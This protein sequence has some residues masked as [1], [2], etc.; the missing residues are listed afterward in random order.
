[1]HLDQW[2]K[3]VYDDEALTK[4]GMGLEVLFNNMSLSDLLDV[5]C[6]RTSIEKAAAK[7]TLERREGLPS[8]AFAVPAGKAK[9]IGVA[10]EIKGEAKGK[11]PIPDLKHAKNALARVSQHGT[12]AEREAVRKKVYAKYP[13]LRES[14]AQRH[15]GESPTEK[16]HVK[17]VE[18]GAIGKTSAAKLAF[19]DKV[20]RQIARQHAEVAKQA[21][22]KPMVKH[23]AFTSPEAQAKAKVLSRAMKASKGAPAQVRKGAIR[24]V[25][26]K[27]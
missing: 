1:M 8:K 3:Q 11:Y 6:G 7:M 10:G 2:L 23:D 26:K 9:K 13:Q 27:L 22:C 16:E 12:P 20:A 5:A 24:A 25:S 14:F 21:T 18:Q 4:E 15:G 19:M 17:K